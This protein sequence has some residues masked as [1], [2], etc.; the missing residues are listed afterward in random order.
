MCLY[1]T[2]AHRY[3]W[4]L[5]NERITSIRSRGMIKDHHFGLTTNNDNG[6]G[7]IVNLS[8]C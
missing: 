1:S 8:I 6:S 7:L 5:P 3:C 4:S 2:P